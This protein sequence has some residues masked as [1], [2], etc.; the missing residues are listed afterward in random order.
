MAR[1]SK[2]D[3]K[4]LREFCSLGCDY[5]GTEEIMNELITDTL[6]ELCSIE[7]LRPD[8]IELNIDD[9][10]ISTLDEFVREF[11]EKAVEAILNVVETQGR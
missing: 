3:M 5:S 6:H 7:Y 9:E 11:W 10:F 2:K 4:E 8:E 1:L